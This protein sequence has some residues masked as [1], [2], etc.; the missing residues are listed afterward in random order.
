[1]ALMLSFFCLESELLQTALSQTLRAMVLGAYVSHPSAPPPPCH[2]I[3][4]RV[5]NMAIIWGFYKLATYADTLINP[6][7][8]SL[9]H[10]ALYSFAR[11]SVW[12]LYSFWTGLFA[13]GLWVGLPRTTFVGFVGEN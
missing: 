8:L 3:L 10:P 4:A 1:M 9:P 12:A 6:Q 2:L 7:T 5:R 13:T 11:F